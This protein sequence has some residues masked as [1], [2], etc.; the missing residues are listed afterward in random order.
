MRFRFKIR[1]LMVVVVM[2]A[3]VCALCVELPWVALSLGFLFLLFLGPMIGASWA[4]RRYRSGRLD[5]VTGGMA[6]GAVQ[7]VLVVGVQLAFS[8]LQTGDVRSELRTLPVQ[9]ASVLAGFMFLGLI[10][11]TFACV[12]Q[13]SKRIPLDK[14][15][16]TDEEITPFL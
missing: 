14:E 7:A 6:G 12:L 2:A 16:V 11:G 8:F 4:A 10:A 13:L 1:T 5:P 9:G 15:I 3:L